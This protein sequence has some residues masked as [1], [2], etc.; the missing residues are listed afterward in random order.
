MTIR[1]ERGM[2]CIYRLLSAPNLTQ[3]NLLFTLMNRSGYS[4]GYIAA[5]NEELSMHQKDLFVSCF[6]DAS[7]G[8]AN[9]SASAGASARARRMR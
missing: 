5:F 7:R 3:G 9:P 6:A 2:V 8:L 4:R 1:R